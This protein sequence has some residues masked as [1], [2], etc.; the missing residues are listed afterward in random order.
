MGCVVAAWRWRQ[1]VRRD[2]T[3]P[4]DVAWAAVVVV[5]NN[6]AAA[7]DDADAAGG[8]GSSSAASSARHR[9]TADDRRP[10]DTSA[11]A[12]NRGRVVNRQ[13]LV[14]TAVHQHR[15]RRQHRSTIR[16]L[17]GYTNTCRRQ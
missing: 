1:Q 14:T 6:P 2:G 10:C 16:F 5:V 8:V 4:C 9:T 17:L 3:P 13:H 15:H 12:V 11:V 7:A